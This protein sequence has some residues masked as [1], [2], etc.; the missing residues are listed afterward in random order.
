MN[1]LKQI[2]LLCLV[3]PA[4]LQAQEMEYLVQGKIPVFT[5]KM[6]AYLMQGNNLD[7]ADISPDGSF[8]FNGKISRPVRSSLLIGETLRKAYRKP[9]ISFYLESGT[10]RLTSPDSIS[11][12][13]V[14][15]GPAN[16]DFTVLSSVVD[17]LNKEQS[18][19]YAWFRKL[20]K[21]EQKSEDVTAKMESSNTAISAKKKEAYQKFLTENPASP[22]ALDAVKSFAGYSPEYNKVFPL[23]QK[24]H[25]SILNSEEGKKYG[26]ELKKYEAVGLGKHAPGFSLPDTAGRIVQL[27]DL[28]G[29]YVL[30]D[31][32][33]SWCGPC[34]TENPHV[35][36]AYE[37][38]KDKGFTVL[39]VSLDDE[40]GKEAWLKAIKDDGLQNWAH[41][42]DLK[43]WKSDASQ[44]YG[45]RAIPS[46]FL[47]DPDGKII[48]KDLRGD[49]LERAL[50]SFIK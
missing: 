45:I 24:L 42:S 31:F 36:K 8:R 48:A 2:S 41:V 43:G 1:W 44:L 9:P 23:F 40:K 19:L 35:V 5:G 28:K 22:V 33:A 10:V 32:W 21:E 17:P 18:N 6:K 26:E 39:G 37:A 50:S 27:S 3:I 16:K 13:V 49:A 15:G 25:P 38:Y 20:P 29:K 11:N 14:S 7:S 46:N 47:L 12:V 4:G 30:L 34:R